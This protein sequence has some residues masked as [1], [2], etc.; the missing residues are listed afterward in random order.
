M[1]SFTSGAAMIV[2]IMTFRGSWTGMRTARRRPMI[3]LRASV[4]FW[5]SVLS[6]RGRRRSAVMPR[7]RSMIPRRRRCITRT[8]R[9]RW[10]SGMA[11]MLV[12]PAAFHK[13]H[14]NTAC[15][16]FSTVTSPMTTMIIGHRQVNRS[17][18]QSRADCHNGICIPQRRRHALNREDTIVAGCAY[19]D[20]DIDV[21]TGLRRQG[22]RN[23]KQ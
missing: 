9:R 3:P 8:R 17:T 22:N 20:V 6:W 16:V 15:T 2:P 13:I 23:R 10:R 4:M 7:R 11:V 14:R 21:H 18:G 1:A 12:V 19:A 5:T